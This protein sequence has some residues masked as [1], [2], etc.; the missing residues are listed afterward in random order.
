MAPLRGNS[1]HFEYWSSPVYFMTSNSWFIYEQWYVHDQS[2]WRMLSSLRDFMATLS[3]LIINNLHEILWPTIHDISVNDGTF[4]TNNFDRCQLRPPSM[5]TSFIGF[6]MFADFLV[7]M[8]VLKRNMTIKFGCFKI[9]R[10]VITQRAWYFSFTMKK[11][12]PY[13]N[14][15]K[16]FYLVR[17]YIM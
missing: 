8:I 9:I 14:A 7:D 1:V 13:V 10:M 5:F 15:K 4:M 17:F 16:F 6:F 2:F 3:S 11:G 12:I